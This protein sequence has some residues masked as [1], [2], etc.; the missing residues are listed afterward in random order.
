MVG[1]D[2]PAFNIK[3]ARDHGVPPY[4]DYVQKIY[5]QNLTDWSQLGTPGFPTFT[6]E[7][8]NL[9]SVYTWVKLKLSF[10]QVSYQKKIFY[11]R[12]G[13]PGRHRMRQKLWNVNLQHLVNFRSPE[14]IDLFIGGLC[15]QPVSGGMLGSVFATIIATQFHN[16]KYGD[17]FFASHSNTEAAFTSGLQ[18]LHTQ[19]PYRIL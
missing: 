7:C 12:R 1:I 11:Q 10:P 9:S 17:R 6:P 5:G 4:A 13:R 14:D 8:Q 18:P 19:F 3:R 15:E 16:Y 2:L